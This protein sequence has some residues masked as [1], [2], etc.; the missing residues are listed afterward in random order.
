MPDHST[1]SR[2]RA[3]VIAWGVAGAVLVLNGVTMLGFATNVDDDL[4]VAVL[5]LGVVVLVLGA[6]AGWRAVWLLRNPPS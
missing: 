6:L 4:R 3:A 1:G 2:G 5:A